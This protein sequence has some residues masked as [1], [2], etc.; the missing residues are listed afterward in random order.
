MLPWGCSVLP[1]LGQQ[2]AFFLVGWPFLK[3]GQC[4]GEESRQASV[5]IYSS[6]AIWQK[7]VKK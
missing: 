3:Q 5:D 6:S 1:E 2:G 4:P 7:L